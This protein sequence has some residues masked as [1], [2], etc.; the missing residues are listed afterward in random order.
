MS[1][2]ESR[3]VVDLGCGLR[4][5][6]DR[7]FF[8]FAEDTAALAG[9]IGYRPDAAKI[10]ELGSGSGG[11]T[12]LLAAANPQAD[13]TGLEIM[14]ANVA[15]AR[16]SLLLNASIPG[17]RRRCRFIEGD[18]CRAADFLAA[19]SFDIIAANPPWQPRQSGRI[20]P[21][22][23]RAAAKSEIFCTLADV[24]AAAALLLQTGGEFFLILPQIRRDEAEALL[25][26]AGFGIISRAAHGT[27]LLWQAQKR[28]NNRIDNRTK[29]NQT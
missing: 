17:L 16:R 23:E 21:I 26:S 20:S 22:P 9:F 25:S 24:I 4:L 3:T 28:Y 14:P 10:C 1:T 13:C 27:R 18:L 7:R 5:W 6:Q 11:L 15:L 8:G 19:G 12:L 2:P 29:N